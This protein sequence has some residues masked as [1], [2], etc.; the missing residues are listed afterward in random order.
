VG[1]VHRLQQAAGNRSVLRVVRPTIARLP[2]LELAPVVDQNAGPALVQR[3]PTQTPGTASDADR[4]DFI[5]QTIRAFREGA[6]L[7][8]DRSV[9]INRARFDRV[10]D[11]WYRM[12]VEQEGII[13]RDLA[14]DATLKRE[15][16]D[17][18]IAAIRVLMSR[19]AEALGTAETDLYRENTGRI[20]MWAW[21]TP[22][23]MEPCISTPIAEGRTVNRRG[24]VRFTTNG[25]AVTI[26]RDRRRRRLRRSA[27]TEVDIKWGRVAFSRTR[28]RGSVVT[29]FTG[30]GQPR[31][32][33]QTAYG[34]RSSAGGVSA[35]GRGTTAEDIA[36]GATS[37]RS[38]RLGF[39]EGSH[40]LASIEF[41]ENNPPPQFT[42][43][44]GMSRADFEA[45]LDQWISECTTYENNLNRFSTRHVDCVGTTIDEHNTRQA[46]RRRGRRARIVLECGP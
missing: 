18:Y 24:Q 4:R 35:Y 42:G 46:G 6:A 19:A 37:S 13:D 41:L 45:A 16:R 5:R 3:Q 15:L 36:G 21:P 28:G 29:R 23:H 30:P 33:I 20:P 11:S 17:A 26:A 31:V 2:S 8:A 43:T 14:G 1:P 34:P 25:F 44:I 38:T 12:I 7:Y 22:H 27:E 39:H 10:I 32:R 9:P 40:G